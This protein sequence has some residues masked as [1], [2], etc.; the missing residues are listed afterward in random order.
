MPGPFLT[1]LSVCRNPFPSTWGSLE[2]SCKGKCNLI[3]SQQRDLWLT[4]T[5]RDLA[6]LI[7]LRGGGGGGGFSPERASGKEADA[8]SWQ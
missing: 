8:P 7:P 6:A 2:V 3:E 5:I 1:L 4:S